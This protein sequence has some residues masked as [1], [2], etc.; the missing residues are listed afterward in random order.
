MHELN[1]N[2]IM[3]AIAVNDAMSNVC[4][5]VHGM[6]AVNVGVKLKMPYMVDGQLAATPIITLLFFNS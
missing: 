5:D 1:N 4:Q 3:I 6:T 2:R